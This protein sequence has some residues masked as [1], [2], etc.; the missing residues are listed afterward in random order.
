M[1]R[2]WENHT[3]RRDNKTDSERKADNSRWLR[4]SGNLIGRNYRKRG[5]NEEML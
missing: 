4:N 1:D 2:G 3:G 5:R